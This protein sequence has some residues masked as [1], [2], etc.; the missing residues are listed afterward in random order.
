[1][2]THTQSPDYMKFI[3][4]LLAIFAIALTILFA[5][6]IVIVDSNEMGVVAKTLGPELPPGQIIARAEEKGVQA[7]ILGPGMHFWYFPWAYDIEKYPVAS[8]KEG[9]IGVVTAYDGNALPDGR[10]FA[11]EW[12]DAKEMLNATTFLKKGYKGPQTTVLGPGQYRYNPSLFEIVSAPA[13]TIREGEVGVVIA[14]DGTAATPNEH[15]LVK[16]GEKGIWEQPLAQGTYYLH[17]QL[18]RV[19]RVKTTQRVYTY[20]KVDRT[21]WQTSDKSKT[22]IKYDDSIQVKSKDGFIFPVNVRIGVVVPSQNAPKLVAL[23]GDPDKI[24]ADPQEGEMLEILEA[25]LVLPPTRSNTRNLAEQRSALEFLNNRTQ[26]EA[27]LFNIL[28]PTFANDHLMLSEVFIDDVGLNDTEQGRALLETLTNKQ[29]AL[30]QKQMYE[31]QRL[32]EEERKMFIEAQTLS[33]RQ[34]EIVA[35]RV[36]IDVK[37]NQAKARA[38]EAQGEAEYIRLIGEAKRDAFQNISTA[39]G[40]DNTARMEVIR[41]LAEGKINITPHVMVT[42]ST[43]ASSGTLEALAGTILGQ[44]SF[45]PAK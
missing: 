28:K 16:R 40:P 2:R 11:P 5:W 12:A 15:G 27:D 43:G 29:I 35:S 38:K 24:V 22:E 13:T 23:L 21:H 34:K 14:M 31:Q 32:A 10:I 45:A 26:V 1:M 37:D 41:L 39:I 7:E 17:P 25:R 36:D 20:Q 19:V 4:G 44:Q 6:A 9:Q 33:D 3:L 30:E 8:I 18:Y 42:G